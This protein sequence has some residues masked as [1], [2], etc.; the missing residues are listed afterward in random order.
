MERTRFWQKSIKLH[1]VKR[2]KRNSLYLYY[3]LDCTSNRKLKKILTLI[4]IY[5]VRGIRLQ[6]TSQYL[7]IP[8]LR[9]RQH[10]PSDSHRHEKPDANGMQHESPHSLRQHTRHERRYRTS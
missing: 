6:I 9:H 4:P 7:L 5:F 2:R 3:T 10:P 1:Q 8:L